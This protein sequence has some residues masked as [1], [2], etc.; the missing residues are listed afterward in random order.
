MID[1]ALINAFAEPNICVMHNKL[2][3]DFKLMNNQ[4]IILIGCVLIKMLHVI[5]VLWPFSRLK[6][7]NNHNDLIMLFGKLFW[8]NHH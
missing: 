6:K 7:K 3:A 8:L 4:A 5:S 1:L 2:M